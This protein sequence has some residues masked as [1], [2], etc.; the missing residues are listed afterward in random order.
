MGAD[1]QLRLSLLCEMLERAGALESGGDPKATLERAFARGLV[2]LEA[3]GGGQ[4]GDSEGPAA[5]RC[6][7]VA[8]RARFDFL[9]HRALALTEQYGELD[10]SVDDLATESLE[11]HHR[12]WAWR[13]R[14]ERLKVQLGRRPG[15]TPRPE[16]APTI[17]SGGPGKNRRPSGERL[18][19]GLERCE[20][21]LDLPA[22][23]LARAKTLD[24]SQGWDEE[25]GEDAPL[26]VLS[27]GLAAL[28]L[29]QSRPGESPGGADQP[30][31]DPSGLDALR[32]R[33]FELS[34]NNRILRIRQRAFEVDNR[35]MRVRLGQLE[36]EVEGL[37]EELSR[38]CGQVGASEER[39]QR[40]LLGRLLGRRS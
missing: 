39:R 5:A 18:L 6:R 38:S 10:R 31:G 20:V 9:R 12:L 1:R 37:E 24:R 35:G 21:E 33:I 2:F 27:H 16:P 26:I 14:E 15:V 36:Q 8:A 22:E 29:E 34:E 23:L 40:W 7:T 17:G 4:R 3:A 32:Y 25:W 13:G 28:E 19:A 11:L 30:V